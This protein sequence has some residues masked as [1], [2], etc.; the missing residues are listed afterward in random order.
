M[1]AGCTA[2]LLANGWTEIAGHE[3][4]GRQNAGYENAGMK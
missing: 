4:D 3:N 1:S 2:P